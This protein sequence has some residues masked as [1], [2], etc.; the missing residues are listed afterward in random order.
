MTGLAETETVLTGAVFVKV[1][2]TV[3]AWPETV[4]GLAETVTVA[5]LALPAM[6]TLDVTVDVPQVC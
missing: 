2:V 5:V 1:D 4:I 3:T 6:V